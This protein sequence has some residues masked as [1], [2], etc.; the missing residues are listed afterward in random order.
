MV[1]SKVKR[2]WDNGGRP[3][4]INL[5]VGVI[6]TLAVG[7]AGWALN[8]T[9]TAMID[10]MD[11]MQSFIDRRITSLSQNFENDLAGV[12]KKLDSK[13]CSVDGR[14]S[15]RVERLE[16]RCNDRK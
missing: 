12:E 11:L 1:V 4:I 16:D 10:R 9:M 3:T 7:I 15:H 2:A 13:I 8:I 5:G 14:L 6:L